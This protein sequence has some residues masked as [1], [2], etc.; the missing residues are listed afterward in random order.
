MNV[1]KKIRA[2]TILLCAI[3]TLGLNLFAQAPP[4]LDGKAILKKVDSFRQFSSSGFSFDFAVTENNGTKSLMRVSLS[5]E[6]K[7]TSIVR[8]MEP[9][10]YR[11]RIVLTLQNS[12]FIYDQGMM[13]PI[14]ITP[15]EMLFG[16]ASAGDITR[17]AFAGMYSIENIEKTDA[18]YHLELKGL[19]NAGATYD[20]IDLT[21]N[22]TDGKPI[23]ADCKGSSGRL[24]K[25]IIYDGFRN[26]QGKDLLTAFTIKDSSTGET[27]TVLLDNFSTDTYPD[28][29]F[30]VE[31]I[32]HVR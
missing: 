18:V 31:A 5:N 21:V 6:N 7:D 28:S 10:K 26:I 30:T 27:S 4:S 32:K 11:R 1:R 19:P 25:T 15:R 3:S 14:R 9:K 20:L 13:S 12:F 16:Q 2:I 23:Q 29:S 8:Y 24:M 22:A 17:I